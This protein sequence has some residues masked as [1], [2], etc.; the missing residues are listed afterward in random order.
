[1]KPLKTLHFS[2]QDLALLMSVLTQ[3]SI[4]FKDI[5]FLDGRLVEDI[6]ITT[7][8][9]TVSHNLKRTPKGWFV[10]TKNANADIWEVSKN[11]A[12]IVFDASATVTASIWIF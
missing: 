10:V 3:W 6:S 4:Q 12:Q 2:D 5:P 8:T 7:D 9:V 1:M 11:S